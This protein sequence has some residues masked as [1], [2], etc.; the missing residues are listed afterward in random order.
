MLLTVLMKSILGD[1]KNKHVRYIIY[2]DNGSGL[3]PHSV[4]K[5]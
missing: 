3:F 5:Y 4:F 2:I 1:R